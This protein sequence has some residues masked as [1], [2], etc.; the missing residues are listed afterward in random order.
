MSSRP[1]R[2]IHSIMAPDYAKR[3]KSPDGAAPPGTAQE[4]WRSPTHH[5]RSPANSRTPS[6]N[7]EKRASGVVLLKQKS[8]AEIYDP[9]S[10]K[11]P[12]SA[13]QEPTVAAK[14]SASL[15][16]RRV[17]PVGDAA[18]RQRPPSRER[19]SPSPYGTSRK[20]P[21]ND[22]AVSEKTRFADKPVLK[23]AARCDEPPAVPQ[24][25]TS[26]SDERPW[27]PQ[28]P[29]QSQYAQHAGDEQSYL[30]YDD[31]EL[32]S[33]T[34]GL[35]STSSRGQQR[36]AQLRSPAQRTRRPPPPGLGSGAERQSPLSPCSRARAQTDSHGYAQHHER[37]VARTRGLSEPTRA[38]SQQQQSRAG[39]DHAHALQQHH[40]TQLRAQLSPEGFDDELGTRSLRASL[41]RML[42]QPD[43]AEPSLQEIEELQMLLDRKKQQLRARAT[44]SSEL[45]VGVHGDEDVDV[46]HGELMERPASSE[47]TASETFYAASPSPCELRESPSEPHDRRP[48]EP[49]EPEEEIAR[50]IAALER[51]PHALNQSTLSHLAEMSR[52]LAAMGAAAMFST[53]ETAS[54]VR[55][56]TEAGT[57]SAETRSKPYVEQRQR[58]GSATDAELEHA[59]QAAEKA[60]AAGASKAQSDGA[61]SSDGRAVRHKH[62]RT[63]SVEAKQ[64]T[65]SPGARRAGAQLEA[66]SR[67][68]NDSRADSRA[69]RLARLHASNTGPNEKMFSSA[70]PPGATSE[71]PLEHC[72]QWTQTGTTMG[73]LCDFARTQTGTTQQPLVPS[74]S[75][76]GGS[77]VASKA[78]VVP[79]KK[80]Q[81]EVVCED[82]QAAVRALSDA[83]ANAQQQQQPE[84]E[85]R[86]HRPIES[87]DQIVGAMQRSPQSQQQQHVH[88]H[89]HH[90]HAVTARQH[91]N[92]PR[93]CLEPFATSAF[94]PGNNHHHA[95]PLGLSSRHEPLDFGPDHHDADRL[96]EI[97]ERTLQRERERLRDVQQSANSVRSALSSPETVI[98]SISEYSAWSCV[99]PPNSAE[100]RYRAPPAFVPRIRLEALRSPRKDHDETILS[101][102]P[103]K[104]VDSLYSPCSAFTPRSQHS[105]D[106]SRA[107]EHSAHSKKTQPNKQPDTGE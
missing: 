93:D 69:E 46:D 83:A 19:K 7:L 84:T 52:R 45:D 61:V 65:S 23:R 55:D 101:P 77:A 16:Q 85:S 26:F 37:T 103:H 78:R 33:I 102:D 106:Q 74:Q 12:R 1:V 6:P 15:K 91:P 73:P 29:Q 67:C 49:S 96:R 44:P 47:Y 17:S 75:A 2:G 8:T 57:S 81:R 80:K 88:H 97:R 82:E 3:V 28:Q 24:S 63:C 21:Q 70:F 5:K 20:S 94:R 39:G 64:R 107:D 42:A 90:H 92:P 60:V 25:R 79:V 87:I 35:N 30:D 59:A 76:P 10:I 32:Q 36:S 66:S 38:H 31:A 14:K 50:T 53:H 18:A 89:H 4:K 54:D 22:K 99:S 98:S 100:F 43:E 104:S 34:S 41:Q 56:Y 58:T 62:Q 40:P 68:V 72:A 9:R 11:S 13:F 71:G 86:V 95:L 48:A 51:L 105:D 27:P